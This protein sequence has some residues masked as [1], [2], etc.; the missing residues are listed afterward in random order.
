MFKNERQIF[1]T[2]N[3]RLK[4]QNISMTIVCVGGFVLSHNGMRATQDID[5]FFRTNKKI[6]SIIKD[7]GDEF[8][9]NTE[10]ELWLN[11]SVQNM[12]KKPDESICEILYEFSNLK[13]LMA[14]LDYIAGMKIQSCREQDVLDVAAI[15]KK[16]KIASPDDLL[17][18]LKN[19]GFGEV[20]ESILLEAFGQAYGM[21]W[22]ENYF[23]ENEKK[24][25]DRIKSS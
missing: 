1:E 19:Y 18:V 23:R 6:E 11:N 3:N 5:G 9:I 14:P 15:I 8:G 12:N 20:D 22:L 4:E 17:E 13:V 24:I 2:L 7:V 21:E 16:M 25:I 10:D